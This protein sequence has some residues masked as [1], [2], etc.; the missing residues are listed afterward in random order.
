AR[1]PLGVPPVVPAALTDH[2]RYRVLELLGHGGMG[3]VY[4]AEHRLMERTVALKV[5][6]H[7][8]TNRPAV[9][10][11]FRREVKA[12]A[13]LDHPNI[14]RAHDAEHAGD[15]HLLVMEC[16]DG[17]ALARLVAGRGPLPVAVACDYV[18]QAALGLQ[19]AFEHGMVHR[20]IKPQNL[21]VTA[22][23]V[24]SAPGVVKV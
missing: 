21:M 18:R 20:D 8:L 4:K 15:T 16:V 24:A 2:P 9:V 23:P 11:R 12:A 22:S 7:E 13:R 1:H 6:K 3:A 19:H 5:I 14:V 10:E 17:I